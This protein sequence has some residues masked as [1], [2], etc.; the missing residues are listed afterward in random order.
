LNQ[1]KESYRNEENHPIIPPLLTC[2]QA[3]SFLLKLIWVGFLAA[4]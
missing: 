3:M 4:V 2:S 1:P